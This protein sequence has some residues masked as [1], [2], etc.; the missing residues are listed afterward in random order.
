MSW[1]TRVSLERSAT[2]CRP[3]LTWLSRFMEVPCTDHLTAVKR[4]LWYVVG[5]RDHGLH[6]T[7]R[8]DE[9]LK[10][11]GYNDAN[12]ASDIDTRRSMSGLIFLLGG[13]TITCTTGNC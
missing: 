6:S 10:L 3:G 2:C 11:V 9:Q 4:I 1:S 12:M 5:T 7:R 8:E 13:N